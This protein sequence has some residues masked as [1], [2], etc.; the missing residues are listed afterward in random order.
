MTLRQMPQAATSTPGAG[1]YGAASAGAQF[2]RMAPH[3]LAFE[4]L[5]AHPPPLPVD[6]CP[7]LDDA[8]FEESVQQALDR[9]HETVMQTWDAL[10]QQRMGH[11]PEQQFL[12][13][14]AQHEPLFVADPMTGTPH[15][16]PW[17]AQLMA[18]CGYQAHLDLQR[19]AKA[20]VRVGA[21]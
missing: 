5:Q 7:P 13:V 2:S 8:E 20:R 1:P 6:F 10:Y 14:W 4:E 9:I 21:A 17:L 11:I 12:Q 3:E 16:N 19:Y 15:P 18:T